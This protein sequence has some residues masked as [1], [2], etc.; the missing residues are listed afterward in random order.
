MGGGR[1]YMF[2]KNQSDVEYPSVAKHSGTR[3]DG[4][5]LVGE[6]IQKMKD[7]V[8]FSPSP[9][10]AVFLL[11]LSASQLHLHIFNVRIPVTHSGFFV[12]WQKGHYVWNKKQLLSL[13]PNNVD[14]L[15]GKCVISP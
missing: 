8:S 3:K 1:K 10:C 14:Y 13:N 6:W 9:V 12:N 7:Y 4:R 2:P 5:N 15:L 11:Q